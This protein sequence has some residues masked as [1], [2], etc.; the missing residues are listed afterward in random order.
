MPAEGVSEVV[1]GGAGHPTL[2][3]GVASGSLTA[4]ATPL[5]RPLVVW[6]HWAFAVNVR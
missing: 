5:K 4:G 2:Q 6:C 1:G 3:A